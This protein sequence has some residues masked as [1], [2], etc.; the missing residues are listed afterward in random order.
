MRKFS[1]STFGSVALALLLLAHG[2]AARVRSEPGVYNVTVQPIK[3]GM[4]HL[5][6][7]Y[8]RPVVPRHPKYLIVFTTGDGG[9]HGVSNQVIEHLAERGYSIAGMSAPDV[10]RPLKRA[11]RKM[12]AVQAADLLGAAFAR[13][14]K[15]LAVAASTRLIVVGYSRG[16]TFAAF[17]AIHSELHADLAGAIAIAL[18]RQADYFRSMAPRAR[19]SRRIRQ[20]KRRRGLIYPALKRFAYVRVAV[21]QSTG[22]RYVRAAESRKLLGPDTATRRLYTV[23]ARNHRFGRGREQLIKDLDAALHWIERP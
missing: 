3:V 1:K 5:H 22:D 4:R 21:I 11:G 20:N 13:F 6:I 18:T 15:D 12:S 2:A 19:G 7:T 23:E 14:R 16:A 10:L 17:T 8:V 9:W